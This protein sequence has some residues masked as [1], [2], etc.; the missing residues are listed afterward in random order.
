MSHEAIATFKCYF[1]LKFKLC[2]NMAICLL[3]KGQIFDAMEMLQ[4]LSGD[5]NEPIAINF[6]TIAELAISNFAD[7][8]VIRFF[9]LY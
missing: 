3:Y 2:N 8:D 9:N 1:F 7:E 4:S 6:S 5:P